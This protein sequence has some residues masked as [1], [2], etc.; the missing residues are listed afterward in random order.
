MQQF[1]NTNDREGGR[2]QLASRQAL[3][4][5]LRH[6]TVWPAASTPTEDEHAR[7]LSTREGIRDLAQG[8]STDLAGFERTIRELD[9][10][11]TLQG[12]RLHHGSPIRLGKALGPI[13]DAVY[14][15]MVDGSWTR[16]KVC[17]RDRCRW[18]YYDASRNAS[19]KWC[20]TEICG[21][22]EKA[23]RAYQR[24]KHLRPS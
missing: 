17:G 20:A 7:A 15:A 18:L 6:W 21:S 4:R 23:R 22:R 13:L 19:A 12:H 10:H 9:I 14:E 3:G 16:M 2:D 5:W 24:K 1:V 11:L 8:T